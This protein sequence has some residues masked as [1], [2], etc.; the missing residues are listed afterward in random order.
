MKNN[1]TGSGKKEQALI[2]EK[3]ELRRQVDN[4]VD[5]GKRRRHSHA[6]FFT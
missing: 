3:N 6:S 1:E 5:D 2:T 4:A